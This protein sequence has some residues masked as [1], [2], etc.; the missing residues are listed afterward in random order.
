MLDNDSWGEDIAKRASLI[1]AGRRQRKGLDKKKPGQDIF[2]ETYPKSPTFSKGP[3][4]Y[5]AVSQ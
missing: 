3:A 5:S 2:S 1:M 4:S